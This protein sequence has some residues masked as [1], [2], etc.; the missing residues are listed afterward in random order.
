MVRTSLRPSTARLH[1]NGDKTV[2]ARLPTGLEGPEK[3]GPAA[4]TKPRRSSAGPTTPR[5]VPTRWLGRRLQ[6]GRCLSWL[7][8][9]ALVLGG[10][11]SPWGVGR[12]ADVPKPKPNVIEGRVTNPDGT[13]ISGAV[14]E[15]AVVIRG[16][17]DA[18]ERVSVFPPVKPDGT[19]RQKVPGGTYSFERGQVR[20]GFQEREYRLPLEPV[21]DLWQNSREPVDG[22]RQDF[23]L[24]LTGPTPGP[25]AGT[26][27]E[28]NHTHW[29]GLTIGIQWQS[30]RSDLRK[31]TTPPPPGTRLVFSLRPTSSRIDGRTLDPLEIERLWDPTK[32]LPTKALNDLPPADYEI[33]GKA[34]RPD[35]K[36]LVL[37]LQTPAEYPRFVPM[38]KAPLQPGGIGAVYSPLNVGF[39]TE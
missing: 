3:S 16:V 33:R 14:R 27:D 10:M 21:G 7:A 34:I 20:L 39:I 30:F 23:L 25:R 26:L 15:V 11:S 2:D 35:G 31:V 32:V 1:G 24:K 12:A 28:N 19:Y 4:W 17:S 36:E 37:L 9:S 38:L 8:A 22:I 18:G 13:P 29:Y 6:A 5:A